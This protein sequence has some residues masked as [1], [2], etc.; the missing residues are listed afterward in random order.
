MAVAEAA[1]RAGSAMVGVT[2]AVI[3]CGHTHV[4]RVMQLNDGRL[5]VN[6]GSVGLQAY[7]DDHLHPHLVENGT[8]HAR[9]ALVT[10][11]REGWRAELRAVPYAQEDRSENRR[12]NDRFQ[13]TAAIGRR[14]PK[15]AHSPKQSLTIFQRWSARDA[16]GTSAVRS[17]E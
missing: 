4:P 16:G 3:L 15:R 1:E 12:A 9:Y 11:R 2:H 6:P 8:P 7:D 5:L 14:A 13:R 10:R 17:P